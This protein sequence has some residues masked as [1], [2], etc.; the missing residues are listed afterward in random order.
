MKS[1]KRAI[2]II[3][4]LAVIL[5]ITVV[6]GYAVGDTFT[7]VLSATSDA[8][9]N[10]PITKASAGETIYIH[11]NFEGNTEENNVC[12]FDLFLQYDENLLTV[13]KQTD[14]VGS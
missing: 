11:V 7:V 12:A 4:S 2:S 5:S 3:L 6:P 14:F 10:T 8:Q 13:A 1:F 9:G